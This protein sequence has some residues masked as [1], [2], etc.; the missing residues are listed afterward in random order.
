MARTSIPL[1]DCLFEAFAESRY[2]NPQDR[3]FL[4]AINAAL[5][6]PLPD[7]RDW[8]FIQARKAHRCAR[9]CLIEEGHLYLA[10]ETGLGWGHVLRIC[11]S[12]MAMI[13]YFQGL[14]DSSSNG[15]KYW[16]IE[17]DSPYEINLQGVRRLLD[18]IEIPAYTA[19]RD[20]DE[21]S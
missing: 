20:A 17:T 9:D 11:V 4:W 3:R 16:D 10:Q 18:K 2:C 7:P 13:L 1:D 8:R 5:A 21:D 15:D 6:R 12:C 19:P 14:A